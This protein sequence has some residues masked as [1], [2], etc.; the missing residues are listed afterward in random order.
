MYFKKGSTAFDDATKY[1]IMPTSFSV[2]PLRS[3]RGRRWAYRATLQGTGDVFVDKTAATELAMQTDM[4]SKVGTVESAFYEDYET[5]GFYLSD[6]TPT[7]HL[8]NTDAANNYTGTLLSHFNWRVTDG[9][10]HVTHK[11]FDF[12]FY[13]D[14]IDPYSGVYDWQDSMLKIG[15]GGQVYDW[16]L[17]PTLGSYYKLVALSSPVK[18][19]QRGRAIGIHGYI[20]PPLPWYNRPYLQGHL[21]KIGRKLGQLMGQPLAYTLFITTWEYVYT[22]PTNVDLYPTIG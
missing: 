18:F 12:G 8:I 11:T 13:A 6:N 22:F 7:Y 15:D 3:P 16:R 21:T 10:D 5:V 4:I 9:A 17:H 1:S 14:F 20:S 2:R 19:V